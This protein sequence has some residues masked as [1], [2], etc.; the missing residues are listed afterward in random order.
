MNINKEK[1]GKPGLAILAGIVRKHPG[2]GFVDEL[3]KD[4]VFH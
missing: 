2:D 3:K 1:P 4:C